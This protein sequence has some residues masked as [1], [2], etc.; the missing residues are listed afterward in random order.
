[1]LTFLARR[2]V[3]GAVM[4]F[5]ISVL[6]FTL[7][8]ST[9][10]NAARRILGDFASEEAVALR[11]QELGL[12]RSLPEQYFDWLTSALT[13]DLGSSWFRAVQVNEELGRR[14]T[15]TLSLVAVS[16]LFSVIIA[17]FVGVLAAVRR[18]T[19]IDRVIQTTSLG[20]AAIPG[21]LWAIALV[22][23]FALNLRWFPAT[24]FVRP[25][26]SIGGWIHS[27]TLPVIALV[28]GGVAS[29]AQQIRG[30]MINVVNQDYVRTLR[31]R[32]LSPRSVIF[33]HSLRNAAGP[34]LAVIALQFVGMLGGAVIV[35]N[36]FNIP[37][38][39]SLSANASIQGDVPILMGIVVII[40][41]IVVVV[42]LLLDIAQG[43][44][45]PKVRVS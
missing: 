6:T 43:W 15:A 39:G 23:L 18:G 25:T 7:L 20:A 34:G 2:I 13:G 32:G 3:T 29:S 40:A 26:D 11:T 38:L 14:L 17:M 1:M 22:M 27:I 8:Y 31:S 12:D 36:L 41:I 21:F 45:N 42:N 5:A 16:L 35:E 10:G 44:L 30:A 9:G 19:W 4:V 28:I 37:G 33:K 24:G